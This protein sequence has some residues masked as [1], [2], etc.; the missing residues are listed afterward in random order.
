MQTAQQAE[1][2]QV[3]GLC[4]FSKLLCPAGDELMQRL[5]NYYKAFF[6]TND[7]VSS[8]GWWLVSQTLHALLLI[9]C[10]VLH[11]TCEGL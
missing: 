11:L 5:L 6:H 8:F 2:K 9:L 4:F 7:G 1:K 3:S 10:A